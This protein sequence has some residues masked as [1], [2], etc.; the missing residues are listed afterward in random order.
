MRSLNILAERTA[1]AVPHGFLLLFLTGCSS[2]QVPQLEFP[3]TP[4]SKPATPTYGPEHRAFEMQPEAGEQIYQA[5]REAK[6]RN[7]V[8]LQIV[9]DSSPIR[10]L[11]LPGDD[12]SVTVSNLLRQTG[13]NK[14]L[15]SIEATLFRPSSDS[16]AGMP[17]AIKMESDGRSARPESDYALRAGDRLR[18]R[19]AASP[20]MK[21][22]IQGI[23]GL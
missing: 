7:A 2:M 5:V 20:A 6:A 23:L 18:V 12:Q 17:L 8:V 14:K 22:L 3:P 19:K 13:V 21:G 16:I 9:G 11:P 1:V 10:V 4:F 15:G